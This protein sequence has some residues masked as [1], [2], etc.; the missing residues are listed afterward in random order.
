M[1]PF[2]TLTSLKKVGKKLC[3]LPSKD[4]GKPLIDGKKA[5][6]STKALDV[7]PYQRN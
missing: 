7:M 5:L 3:H 4:K 1:L 6:E 2:K